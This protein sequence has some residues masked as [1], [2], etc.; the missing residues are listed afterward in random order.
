MTKSKIRIHIASFPSSSLLTILIC[1]LYWERIWLV[2]WSSNRKQVYNVCS[3]SFFRESR[4]NLQHT[5]RNLIKINDQSLP[6]GPPAL[7][8]KSI[9]IHLHMNILFLC[10]KHWLRLCHAQ[11]VPNLCLISHLWNEPVHWVSTYGKHKIDSH[12]KTK[13]LQANLSIITE[14]KYSYW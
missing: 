14:N 1:I 10:G 6:R 2:A 5:R 11:M 9:L 13:L 7:D 4:L 8:G 12:S 3:Q